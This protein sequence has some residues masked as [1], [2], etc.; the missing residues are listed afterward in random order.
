[1]I[2]SGRYAGYCSR[3]PSGLAVIAIRFEDIAGHAVADAIRPGS[4][5]R[6]RGE[7]RT[8]PTGEH[9]KRER[10]FLRARQAQRRD[11][12]RGSRHRDVLVFPVREAALEVRLEWLAPRLDEPR[13]VLSLV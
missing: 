9:E 8:P 10:S 1:M 6:D 7:R 2:P 5:G 12:P 11:R 4:L 13:P 3:R